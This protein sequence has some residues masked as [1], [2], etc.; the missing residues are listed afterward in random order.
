MENKKTIL[1]VD[2]DSAHRTMLQTLLNG[3]GYTIMEANDG[4]TAIEKVHE[5]AFDLI[6]MDIRMVKVSGLKALT[7]IRTFNP[8]IPVIIMTAYSSVESAVEALKNGAYDYLTKPLDFDELRLSMERAMDHRRLREEN[9]LLRESLG[10]HFDRRNIIGSSPAMA[11]LLETVAQVAPSEA[12]VL[13]AGESG[14]GKEMIAGAIHFNSPRK[15]GPFVKINCAAITE[16]LLES[17]LFG[18]EKG[19]FTGAYRTKEGR[20]RQAHGGS[21]FLDEISEMSLAMQVKV[22]RVLQEREIMRVGGEEV[23]PVDVRIIA[24]TNKDLSQ[25]IKAGHFREDL[26]YRLNVVALNM[27]PLRER[28]G[29]IPLLAQHF[30]TMFCRTN[31]K[32]IKG[33]T[34]QGMDMLLRYDWP[35]NVRELMNAV[36]RGVVLSRSEYITEEELPLVLRAAPTTDKVLLKDVLPP[37]TPLNEVERATILKTLETLGGNKSEAARHLGI[38]RK[39]LH[40][41]LKLYGVMP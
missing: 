14:T 32:H 4:S 30:L 40:K 34:P 35:G 2:D 36:E 11:T 31:R 9:Q 8:A 15:D 17:E 7:E 23:I 29:D 6:L 39:T 1:V 13:I 28:R 37:D 12:T 5:Q 38:T 33:F 26:Y 24:A 19:A 21:L 3:W 16:T 20:F 25:E 10:R 41:K 22:L 27:P 18:H